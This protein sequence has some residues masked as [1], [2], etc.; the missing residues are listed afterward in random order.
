[1]TPHRV[2]PTTATTAA[3]TET[4]VVMEGREGLRDLQER[5]SEDVALDTRRA[6]RTLSV[7]MILSMPPGTDGTKVRDAVRAF[8]IALLQDGMH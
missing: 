3:E 1:M 4:G 2:L 7:N 6:N 5:W 8:A